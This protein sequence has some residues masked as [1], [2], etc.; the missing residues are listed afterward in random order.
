MY[1]KL[2][3]CLS[4]TWPHWW[5]RHLVPSCP[6][7]VQWNKCPHS[8]SSVVHELFVTGPPTPPRRPSTSWHRS[9]PQRAGSYWWTRSC[10]CSPPSP[11]DR[12]RDQQHRHRD[13]Q[14]RHLK[15]RS[16]NQPPC[17]AASY[18][19]VCKCP[20]HHRGGSL[21]HQSPGADG[22]SWREGGAES[23]AA[24][25]QVVGHWVFNHPQELLWTISRSDTQLVQQLNWGGR[26]QKR[27]MMTCSISA[28]YI[29]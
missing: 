5:D 27:E 10:L 25:R 9:A 7:L 12:H 17:K 15:P 18:R 29:N 13:Q 20:D 23:R 14:H 6:F 3:V 2:N 11:K 1:I 22:L 24:G 26:R 28:L 19:S 8:V 21:G 16:V 4:S